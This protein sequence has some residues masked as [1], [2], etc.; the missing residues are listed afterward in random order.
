MPEACSQYLELTRSPNPC[1]ASAEI[2]HEHCEEDVENL[3]REPRCE[4]VPDR[5]EDGSEE[6]PEQPVTGADS[7]ERPEQPAPILVVAVV[8]VGDV[9]SA[10]TNHVPAVGNV[11]ETVRTPAPVAVPFA[12]DTCV[13]VVELFV[14]AWYTIAVAFG[15]PSTGL[16]AI[17]MS[18]ESAVYISVLGLTDVMDVG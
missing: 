7:K 8:P 16:S 14:D 1:E 10:Y 18:V 6:L 5:R 12:V 9:I 15:A 17:V 3:P 13:G 11:H 2:E 4:L